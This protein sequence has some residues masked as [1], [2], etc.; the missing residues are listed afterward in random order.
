MDPASLFLEKYIKVSIVMTEHHK[1]AT[2]EGKG[3][4]LL[5][6][7]IAV[8]QQRNKSSNSRRART[9]EAGDDTGIWLPDLLSQWLAQPASLQ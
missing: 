8:D 5:N 3:L 7:H 4:L 6:F 1:H 9:W 2:W